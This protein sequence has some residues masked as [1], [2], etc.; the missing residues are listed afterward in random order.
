M[1]NY[2]SWS[3]KQCSRLLQL[4]QRYFTAS[5]WLLW[6][7]FSS[8]SLATVVMLLTFLLL[9]TFILP[10]RNVKRHSTNKPWVT[11]QFRRL[12]RCRQNALKN[13]QTDR[14][15]LYGNNVQRA[16]KQLRRKFYAREIHNLR[17]SDQR[18]W[19]RSVKQ[20]TGLSRS[21]TKPLQSLANQLHDGD[22]HELASSVNLF[23]LQ[24]AADFCSR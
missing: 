12:I 6:R 5:T 13:G 23:F 18:E 24:V 7:I 15:K 22:M 19:W 16:T 20:I 8:L 2:D 4:H 11:D 9:Y 10:L 1:F 21:S 3:E 14:C 17:N